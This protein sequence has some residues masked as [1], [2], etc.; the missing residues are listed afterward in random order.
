MFPVSVLGKAVVLQLYVLRHFV[1][2]ADC[3]TDELSGKFSTLFQIKA[4]VAK[5]GLNCTR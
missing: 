1:L 4:D 2:Q 3:P 5:I